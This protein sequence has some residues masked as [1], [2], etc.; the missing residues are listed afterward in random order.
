MDVYANVVLGYGIHYPVRHGQVEN[1]VCLLDRAECYR[2]RLINHRT[3]WKGS[4]QTQFSNI[5]GW[6]PKI[7][8]FSSQN[9]S[10]D[11]F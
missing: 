3:I 8:T 7:I 1:W 11:S 10:V 9:L 5:F 4:G 6:N 2:S